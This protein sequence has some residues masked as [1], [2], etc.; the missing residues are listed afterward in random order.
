MHSCVAAW[1]KLEVQSRLQGSFAGLSEG[2]LLRR[3]K[4]H[5]LQHSTLVLAPQSPALAS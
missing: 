5:F 4:T 2:H 3:T 1:R